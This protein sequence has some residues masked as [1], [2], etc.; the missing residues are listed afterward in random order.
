MKLKNTQYHPAMHARCILLSVYKFSSLKCGKLVLLMFDLT[1]QWPI[2]CCLILL[3]ALNVLVKNFEKRTNKHAISTG[4]SQIEYHAIGSI[5]LFQY[6]QFISI[7][8]INTNQIYSLRTYISSDV[9]HLLDQIQIEI[10]QRYEISFPFGF[11]HAL[12]Y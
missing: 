2:Y 12:H 10:C 6:I 3:L 5:Q 8:R 11:T 7:D 1:T 4:Q 9:K